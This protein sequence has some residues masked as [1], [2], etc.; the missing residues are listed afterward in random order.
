MEKRCKKLEC[1]C[2][3]GWDCGRLA[4]PDGTES[5]CM[6]G[7]VKWMGRVTICYHD[8]I[9]ALGFLDHAIYRYELS[10]RERPLAMATVEQKILLVLR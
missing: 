2:S 1:N 10:S 9:G 3:L 8:R 6:F 5:V 7:R 4:V